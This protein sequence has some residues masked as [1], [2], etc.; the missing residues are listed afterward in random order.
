MIDRP[1]SRPGPDHHPM[2]PEYRAAVASCAFVSAEAVSPA[3]R[4]DQDLGLDSLALTELV[5][6]LIVDFGWD[7][8]GEDLEER[9]WKG[10]TVGELFGE[11]IDAKNSSA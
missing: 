7:A 10:T 4:L 9:E 5:V 1:S 6:V 3:M 8:L 2:W 11:L